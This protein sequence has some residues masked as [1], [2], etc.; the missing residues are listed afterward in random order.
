MS[1]PALSVACVYTDE[2]A[3]FP[4]VVDPTLPSSDA[5]VTPEP[6]T[7]WLPEEVP[8]WPIQLHVR[9]A[10]GPPVHGGACPLAGAEQSGHAITV[11]FAQ[12]LWP[13]DPPPPPPLGPPVPELPLLPP[14]WPLEPPPPLRSCPGSA[15]FKARFCNWKPA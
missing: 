6:V 13:L 12:L 14:S 2:L 9:H 10:G 15:T 3:S 7:G 1:S 8:P 11:L 5:A 4:T